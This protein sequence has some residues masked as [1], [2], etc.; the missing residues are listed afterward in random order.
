MEIKNF[1]CVF[2]NCKDVKAGSFIK[3]GQEIKYNASKKVV[4]GF[5]ENGKEVTLECKTDKDIFNECSELT[6]YQNVLVDLKI[7]FS[8]MYPKFVLTSIM[9]G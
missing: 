7:D 4:L 3:D 8:S 9:E 6:P 5:I 1:G 2:K